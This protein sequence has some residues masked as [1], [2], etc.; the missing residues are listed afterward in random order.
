ML[1]W[2]RLRNFMTALEVASA[3]RDSSWCFRDARSVLGSMCCRRWS[4]SR[5][6]KLPTARAKLLR[7]LAA[8]ALAHAG[9][10]EPV[11]STTGPVTTH[12]KWVKRPGQR[13][14]GLW[15]A[16]REVD[17][18]KDSVGHWAV[19]GLQGYSPCAIRD[20]RLGEGPPDWHPGSGGTRPN[21]RELVASCGVLRRTIRRNANDHR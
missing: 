16:C 20:S 21:R 15:V 12:P 3:D 14:T 18:V 7:P 8:V 17:P 4:L 2:R 5:P 6:T 10:R 13:R 9:A 11:L 1:N 19:S